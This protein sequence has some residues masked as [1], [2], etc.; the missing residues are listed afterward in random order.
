VED[1]IPVRAVIVYLANMAGSKIR[2]MVPGHARFVLP[3]PSLRPNRQ[4]V[5]VIEI[6]AVGRM[7]HKRK[8][9]NK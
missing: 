7:I 1:W 2:A 5:Q 9:K 3:S 8:L 6:V 4:Q